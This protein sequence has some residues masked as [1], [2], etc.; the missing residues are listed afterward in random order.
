MAGIKDIAKGR[1]D[2]YRVVVNDLHVKEG[3]NS[4]DEGD[5]A[6]VEHIEALAQ[7]IATVGVKEPLTANLEDGKLVIENGHCRRAAVLLAIEKYKADPEMLIPVRMGDR[8]ASEGDRI[9]SQIIRN[10]GKPLS[11]LETASVYKKL[12]DLGLSN[13]EIA[14]KAGVSRVYVGQ[15]LDLIAMPEK[16]LAPVRK[17]EI[18]STL[19]IQIMKD[20]NNDHIE[21]A[22]AIREAVGTAKAAGKDRATKKHVKKAEEA[23]APAKPVKAKDA[24]PKVDPMLALRALVDGAILSASAD[25]VTLTFTREDYALLAETLGARGAA[26]NED[27]I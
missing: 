23:P 11:P 3:W 27:L 21:T 13:G 17:G 5:R 1:S 18:S 2:L 22:R 6:N 8:D 19:A 14:K 16:V 9:L 20:N 26:Q 25:H 7:S 24:A 10:S 12:H 4:R 15:L